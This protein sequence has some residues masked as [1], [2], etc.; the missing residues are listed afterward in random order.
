MTRVLI[1]PVRFEDGKF[2]FRTATLPEGVTLEAA[3]PVVVYMD[4]NQQ[5]YSKHPEGGWVSPPWDEIAELA[6]S[7]QEPDYIDHCRCKCHN[8]KHEKND[9]DSLYRHGHCPDC[10]RCP[11]A[12]PVMPQIQYAALP[13]TSAPAVPA[14]SAFTP[15]A[16]A[17]APP[18]P[19]PIPEGGLS[20][21][22]LSTIQTSLVGTETSLADIL[23]NL[24]PDAQVGT[25]VTQLYSNNYNWFSICSRCRSWQLYVNS[26][27]VCDLCVHKG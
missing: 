20:Y 22:E 14:P 7:G 13:V 16:Q 19:P 15:A 12:A 21:H 17:P 26:D 2:T 5:R 9:F 25:V 10:P 6:E 8:R 11:S 4:A 3:E 23:E 24:F 18:P 1:A 27:R